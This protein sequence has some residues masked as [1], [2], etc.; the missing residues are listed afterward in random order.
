[1]LIMYIYTH[2]HKYTYTIC[3]VLTSTVHVFPVIITS[4]RHSKIRH[5]SLIIF[6]LLPLFIPFDMTQH[7]SWDRITFQLGQYFEEEY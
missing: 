7:L 3:H 2:M 5:Q 6:S 4:N 1:M